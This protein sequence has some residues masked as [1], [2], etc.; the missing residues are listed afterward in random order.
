PLRAE[1]AVEIAVVGKQALA[2]V[3]L[4]AGQRVAFQ[5]LG[6]RGAGTG[7]DAVAVEIGAVAGVE[8]LVRD[9]REQ[10]G[11]RRD[12]VVVAHARAPA[13]DVDVGVVD[14]LLVERAEQVAIRVH[15]DRAVVG[16]AVG[17][18]IVV[19]VGGGVAAL[20]V[21]VGH[22]VG[23]RSGRGEGERGYRQQRGG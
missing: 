2:V 10:V 8:L 5:A 4:V 18:E 17:V 3:V 15:G 16:P 9:A 14:F 6:Q 22:A 19:T 13:L 23:G 21:V 7:L 11:A 20:H 12:L 1:A